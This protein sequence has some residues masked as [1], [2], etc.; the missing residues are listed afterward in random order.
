MTTANLQFDPFAPGFAGDPYEQYRRL[1]ERDPV[2]V[3]ALGTWYLFG[4]TDIRDF[5]RD[6]D[7][8]VDLS[9]AHPTLMTEL[10]A[11]GLGERSDDNPVSFNHVM[12]FHDPPKHTRLR[13][14]VQ[15][16]FTAR[17]VTNLR[18]RISRIV[19]AMLDGVESAGECD[20]V[21]AFTFPLPFKVIT[22]LIGADTRR[23]DEVRDWSG[24]LVQHLD[25]TVPADMGQMVH[26]ATEIRAHA[27]DI[28]E[29]KRAN[30]AD[31]LLTGLIQAE[32]DGETL[33]HDELVEQVVFLYIAGHE[34][35]V[36]LLGNGSLA[37]LGHPDQ[38][39]L[40]GSDPEIA[41]VAPD[42]LLRYDPPVQF[43][44]RITVS[45]MDVSGTTIE[46][47]ATVMLALGSA[48]RDRDFWGPDA[49]SLDLRRPN[50]NEHVAFGGGRHY[51]IGAH[52][53]RTEAE[54]G[55]GTM[56]RRFPDLRLAGEAK[57][58]GRINL[59]GVSE[60]PVAVC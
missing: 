37:L 49:D 6:P 11:E 36:N 32:E 10:L 45:E 13:R 1:R 5:L 48:H 43:S 12:F 40:L 58:N 7:L 28:I 16:A 46:E 50:A 31:D 60:L 39:R 38:Y 22:E 59:R 2:H 41:A 34:T 24:V 51:C 14:L 56:A 26:A 15:Q 57:W 27:D 30:P 21:E 47:G 17:I 52:L 8:S 20:L 42:E 29:W 54:I 9:R 44:R 25:P 18:P 35:T 55:L 53:A 4:H 33:S 3:D 23:S 19:D